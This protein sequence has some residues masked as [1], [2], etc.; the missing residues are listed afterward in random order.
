L[1]GW[2]VVV[3]V[4]GNGILASILT[5]FRLIHGSATWAGVVLGSVL[6]VCGGGQC[7][8]ILAL[9]F[10]LGTL[11]T[12]HG[13]ERKLW[14]GVAQED[15]G[16]RGARHVVANCG[17]PTLCAFFVAA[18][19]YPQWFKIALVASLATA[20]LD[21]LSSELGQVYGRYP[22][23]PTTG[24]TVPIGTE[25]AISMEGTL[26]GLFGAIFLAAVAWVIGAIPPSAISLVVMAAFIG[27]SAESVIAAAIRS[28]FTWRNEIFNITNT[29]IGA[30]VA[31]VVSIQT[32]PPA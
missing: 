2:Y 15:Q 18:T 27:G 12:K 20:L 7:Y 31:L 9:F 28:D 5:S 29:A 24:E 11:A 23:L 6:W 16:R 22:V 14:R 25:G 3:A 13:Y 17:V 32:Q 19:P 1:E 10:I 21:T 26:A 30:A 4:A 8:L